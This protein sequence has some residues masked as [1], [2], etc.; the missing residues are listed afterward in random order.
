MHFDTQKRPFDTE[1]LC[2]REEGVIV[3]SS[4]KTVGR[5]KEKEGRPMQIEDDKGYRVQSVS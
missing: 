2:G 3:E 1:R 4:R 5:K